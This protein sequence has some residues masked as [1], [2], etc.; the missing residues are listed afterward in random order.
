[1]I[2]WRVPT[3]DEIVSSVEEMAV[4]ASLDLP[5][6]VRRAL[7]F[8]LKVET[9]ELAR[10]A[11]Q[12]LLDNAEIAK[13][14]GLPLCQDTGTFHLFVEVGGGAC[15]PSY[16]REAAEE[17]LRRATRRVPLRPSQVMDLLRERKNTGD[18]TPVR[19]HLDF[20]PELEGMRL[21]L[22]AKGGGSE[23]V[24]SLCMLLPGDGAE[25]V[26]KAVLE[27]VRRKAA[28]ACPP[29]VVGV[30]V[31]G[32]AEECLQLALKGLLRPLGIRNPKPHLA[33]L[34]EDL[35]A[36]VNSLGI[37]A[38]GLGGSVTALDVHLEEA[39]AHMA[40]FPVGVV[41]CCHSLRRAHKLIPMG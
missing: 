1:M 4:Q 35:L 38:A 10:Y 37:G 18:N 7:E 20:Q 40:T 28:S 9:G 16:L 8:A 24:T 34:E 13:R 22:L 39:P 25:G 36:K 33:E 21:S 23:N 2:G 30:G 14:E 26:R 15:L 3:R 31:G 27:A 41:I 32:D 5:E 12:I 19:V 17:G 29:V 6:D 11:L